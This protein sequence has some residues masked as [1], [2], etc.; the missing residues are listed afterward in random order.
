VAARP[1]YCRLTSLANY[2][3]LMAIK[4]SQGGMR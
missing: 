2:I 4:I 1:I 3:S